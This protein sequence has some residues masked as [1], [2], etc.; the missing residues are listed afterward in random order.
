MFCTN[1]D[2]CKSYLYVKTENKDYNILNKAFQ[3][4]GNGSS[5]A[6]DN[7]NSNNTK[8]NGIISDDADDVY[9]A[10]PK[11]WQKCSELWTESSKILSFLNN[12]NNEAFNEEDLLDEEYYNINDES[13]GLNSNLNEKIT[14]ILEEIN[15]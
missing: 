2:F 9:N 7:V 14:I 8:N 11:E 4:F 1:S 15:Y 10:L 6:D 3:I 12:N 5:S 13:V